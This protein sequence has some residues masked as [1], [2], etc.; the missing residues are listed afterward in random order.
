MQLILVADS[1][2][3]VAAVGTT[4]DLEI[5][6]GATAGR[7]GDDWKEPVGDAYPACH[8][9]AGSGTCAGVD[10]GLGDLGSGSVGLAP[11]GV[12][13]RVD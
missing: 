11:V 4:N 12:A 10:T 3:A 7:P 13:V 9:A 1:T 6:Q 5:P 8:L 2:A